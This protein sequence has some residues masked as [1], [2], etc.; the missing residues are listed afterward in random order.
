MANVKKTHYQQGTV[1]TA[2]E[3]NAPYDDLATASASVAEDNTASSWATVKHFNTTA[4]QCNRLY[5]YA[6]DGIGVD[7]I[8]SATYVTVNVVTA[9][10]ID[11]TGFFPDQYEATRY[12]ASG[13]VRSVSVAGPNSQDVGALNYY[14]FRLLLTYSDGGGADATTTI[15]EW[16]YSL[17]PRSR[18]TDLSS[19][20]ES[21]IQFQTFQFSTVRRYDGATGNRQYKKLELQVKLNN[22]LNSVSISRNQIFAI[23]ARR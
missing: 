22:N 10:E 16:G 15:G 12:A 13:L 21:E 20:T 6:Y 23:S 2:A 1:P 8:N 19:G 5:D 17:T 3:L 4:Q 7:T 18:V 14:A 11:L 9:S